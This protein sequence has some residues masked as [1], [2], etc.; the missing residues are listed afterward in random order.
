MGKWFRMN[1]KVYYKFACEQCRITKEAISAVNR[2]GIART[3]RQW[4]HVHGLHG[5]VV[6]K[7]WPVTLA[8]NQSAK[9]S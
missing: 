1:E 3:V 2:E 8:S 6:M 5:V 4:V 9:E 7:I